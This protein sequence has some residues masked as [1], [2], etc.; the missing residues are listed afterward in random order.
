MKDNTPNQNEKYIDMFLEAL[1][2]VPNIFKGISEQDER[3]MTR[4]ERKYL[5]Y[6]YI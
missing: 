4:Q 1:R 5:E 3:P 2:Q 6:R